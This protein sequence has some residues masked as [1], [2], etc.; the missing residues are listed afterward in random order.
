MQYH[1]LIHI[2]NIASHS[3]FFPEVSEHFIVIVNVISYLVAKPVNTYLLK[4]FV[5]DSTVP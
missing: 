5:D 4:I 2:K 3:K 1:C